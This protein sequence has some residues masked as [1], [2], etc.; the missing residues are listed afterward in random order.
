[1]P[2]L[3]GERQRRS[4]CF[5][6]QKSFR[7]QNAQTWEI[8]PLG[9]IFGTQPIF[10]KRSLNPRVKRG[11]HSACDDLKPSRK[12]VEHPG[13]EAFPLDNDRRM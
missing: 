11:F 13:N 8:Y 12:L 2:K 5:L 9:G 10:I 6:F 1:M 3:A 4:W 7:C